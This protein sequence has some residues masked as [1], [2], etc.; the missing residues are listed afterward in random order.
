ML[1]ASGLLADPA[2]AA[3]DA[4]TTYLPMLPDPLN[5]WPIWNSG[6]FVFQ[7]MVSID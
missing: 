2:A 3:T 7:L 6:F 1:W 4:K 5:Y